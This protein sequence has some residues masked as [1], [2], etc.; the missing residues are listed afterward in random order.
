MALEKAA[1]KRHIPPG[2]TIEVLFNPNEYRLNVSNQFAEV[3]IPGLAA[4]LVQFGRGN[5]STLSMRL[6]FD[7]YEQRTDVRLYTGKVIKLMTIDP[8]LHA[9]PVCMFVWGKLEFVGVLERADQ[10]FTLF[11]PNGIPVRAA[12][13]VSFKEFFDGKKQAGLLESAD[14]AKRYTVQRGDT[15]SSIAGVE[16]GDH[17]LWRLIAEENGLDDPLA[18]QPGQVLVIPAVR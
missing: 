3:A 9:P 1:I 15:L 18:L 16:Y 11:L 5:A 6:F 4:P 17:A 12:L 13:D 14:F 10:S 7:T 8:S 2:E